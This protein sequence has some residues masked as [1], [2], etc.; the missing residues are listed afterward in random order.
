MRK[1]PKRKSVPVTYSHALFSFVYKLFFKAGLGLAPYGLVLSILVWHSL[2]QRFI[3][4]FK[5]TSHIFSAKFKAKTLSCFWVNM[6]C[7]LSC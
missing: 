2:V 6:V 4:K 5:T 7:V 3:H 1:V